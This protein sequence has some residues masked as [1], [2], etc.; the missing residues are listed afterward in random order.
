VEQSLIQLKDYENEQDLQ[1][2]AEIK[3]ELIQQKYLKD[4]QKQEQSRQEESKPHIY[5]SPSGFEVWV[6]RNNKQNDQLTF[7]IA[8]DYDLWFHTQEIAGSH[9]LLRLKPGTVAEDSDLQFTADLAAYYSRSRQS[10]Q[11]PVVYTQPKFVYKPKG[12]KPG[13]VVYKKEKV[14]WG[15]P[16]IIA[17]T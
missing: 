8:G 15:K 10:E 11:V 2:L 12:A 9:V 3:E 13:M 7:R 5:V 17:N 6:G 16:H 1:T 14:L 4:P